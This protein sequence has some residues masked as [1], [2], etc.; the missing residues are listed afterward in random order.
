[1]SF[2]LKAALRGIAP[3]L[4]TALGGPAAGTA[5]KVLA[6]VLLGKD[7][8]TQD[9]LAARVGTVTADDVLKLKQADQAFALEMARIAQGSDALE[10]DDRKNARAREIA[11]HDWV[12]N[13]LA[14]A[15]TSIFALALAGLYFVPIPPANRDVLIQ[16]VGMVGSVWGVVVAYYFG[17]SLGSRAKDATIGKALADK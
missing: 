14:I 10:I 11:T 17:T 15:V 8:A 5:T 3:A 2:D 1:M 4:A 12:T 13:A 16:A 7:D 9:E 6:G